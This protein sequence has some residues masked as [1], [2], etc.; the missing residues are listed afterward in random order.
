MKTHQYLAW[1]LLHRTSNNSTAL[2]CNSVALLTELFNAP[3]MAAFMSTAIDNIAEK[4]TVK[5]AMEHLGLKTY[6]L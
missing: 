1:T 4:M 3:R 6:F 2:P 5:D